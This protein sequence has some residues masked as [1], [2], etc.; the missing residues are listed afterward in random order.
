M[1]ISCK[2]LLRIL[3]PQDYFVFLHILDL[4]VFGYAFLIIRVILLDG[5]NGMLGTG[6]K[7]GGV[8]FLD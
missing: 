3:M 5:L 2:S 7:K 8:S 1:L 6:G 4:C